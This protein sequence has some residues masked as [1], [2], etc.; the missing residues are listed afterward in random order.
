V[1]ALMAEA[2]P[3]FDELFA[4][5]ERRAAAGEIPDLGMMLGL[6]GNEADEA[7]S[8]D[9]VNGADEARS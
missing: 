2:P 9:E 7:D 4:E 8:A 6:F 5:A 3:G 1:Q